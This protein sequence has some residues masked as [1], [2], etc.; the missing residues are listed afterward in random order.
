[1]VYNIVIS[2]HKEDVSDAGSVGKRQRGVERRVLGQVNVGILL[3]AFHRRSLIRSGG[4]E[5]SLLPC[6][7]LD[8]RLRHFFVVVCQLR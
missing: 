3:M 4:I 2:T 7:I 6:L 5:G 1:M 8:I